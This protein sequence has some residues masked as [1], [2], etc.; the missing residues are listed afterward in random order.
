MLL[1]F[2]NL[3]TGRGTSVLEAVSAFEAASGTTLETVVG[4]RRE[5]DVGAMYADA[6][7]AEKVLGWKA[8][9]GVEEAMRDAWRWQ[10]RLSDRD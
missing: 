9:L 4:P 7:K 5:G 2:F 1:E 10:R 6:T 3:G 8:N